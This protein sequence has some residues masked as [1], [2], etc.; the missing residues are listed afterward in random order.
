MYTSRSS[1]R[2]LPTAQHPRAKLCH[3]NV[4][5][6]GTE[7]LSDALQIYPKLDHDRLDFQTH[8]EYPSD[9]EELVTIALCKFDRY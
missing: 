6:E 8:V 2:P 9:T 5:D 1:A 4:L 7:A 3:V